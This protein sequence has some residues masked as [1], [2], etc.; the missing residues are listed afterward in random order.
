MTLMPAYQLTQSHA[1]APV[2][3]WYRLA[4]VFVRYAAPPLMPRLLCP[5]CFAYFAGEP[6]LA[7]AYHD[8]PSDVSAWW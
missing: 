6:S 5:A 1:P 7:P 4:F 3:H 2:I 8:V